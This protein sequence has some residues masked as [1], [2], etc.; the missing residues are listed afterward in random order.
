LVARAESRPAQSIAD[1]GQPDASSNQ[2][3]LARTGLQLHFPPG[4]GHKKGRSDER[5]GLKYDPR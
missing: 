4:G 5:C 3:S 1:S 2:F